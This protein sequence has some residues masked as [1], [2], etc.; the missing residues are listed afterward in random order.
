MEEVKGYAR[1]VWMWFIS[2]ATY[3][4][5]ATHCALDVH[6]IAVPGVSVANDWQTAGG[7]VD[8][9]TLARRA[10]RGH[11]AAGCHPGAALKALKD[12][13]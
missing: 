9:A 7:F 6:G 2:G 4:S 1:K 5:I 8:G 3:L 10:G 12:A 13:D 11:C